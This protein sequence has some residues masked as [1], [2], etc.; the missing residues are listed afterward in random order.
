MDAYDNYDFV[1]QHIKNLRKKLVNGG[2]T[3]YIGTIYGVGYQFGKV[4]GAK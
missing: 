1:Y 2:C 4:K 3:D